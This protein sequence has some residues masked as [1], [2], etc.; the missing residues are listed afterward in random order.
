MEKTTAVTATILT[1]L[2]TLWLAVAIGVVA[3]AALRRIA[4]GAMHELDAAVDPGQPP[5]PPPDQATPS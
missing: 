1:R 4:P 5:A 3:L 2:A